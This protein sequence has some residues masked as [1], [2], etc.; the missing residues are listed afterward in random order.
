MS[1]TA[2]PEQESSAK[3]T[4]PHSCKQDK[5][6]G[7]VSCKTSHGLLPLY[8]VI[9]IIGLVVVVVGIVVWFARK[10]MGGADDRQSLLIAQPRDWLLDGC[11]GQ[12]IVWTAVVQGTLYV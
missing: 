11:M 12:C 3:A 10:R 1:P 9:G 7:V 8:I 4:S 6:T 2:P 5:E